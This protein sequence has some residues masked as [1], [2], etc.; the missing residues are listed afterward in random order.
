MTEQ[1][2]QHQPAGTAEQHNGRVACTHFSYDCTN[3]SYAVNSAAFTTSSSLPRSSM[4]LTA[5]CRCSPA[6]NGALVVPA[7]WSHTLSS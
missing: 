4:T 1:P 6:S 2:A 3:F 5:T 7:R